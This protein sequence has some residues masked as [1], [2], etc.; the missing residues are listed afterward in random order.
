ME[1]SNDTGSSVR[2]GKATIY[3]YDALGIKIGTR[4]AYAK[5]DALAPGQATVLTET[6]PSMLY[7][8]GGS[9]TTPPLGVLGARPERHRGRPARRTTMWSSAAGSPHWQPGPA[10]TSPPRERR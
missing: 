8:Q 6:M 3:I 7:D 10:G 2:L 9:T 1:L 4:Y 5:A